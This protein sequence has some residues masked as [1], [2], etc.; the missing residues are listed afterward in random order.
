MA[1]GCAVITS[2]Y[3]GTAEVIGDT[4]ITIDPKDP[5][6][7]TTALNKLLNDKKLRNS[8]GKKA[9]KRIEA[10]YDW[11]IISDKYIE[12]KYNYP[13]LSSPVFIWLSS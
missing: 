8:L 13:C 6:E 1:A 12:S 10:H 2:K 9:R 5:K 3:S 7:F 11:S 4:G